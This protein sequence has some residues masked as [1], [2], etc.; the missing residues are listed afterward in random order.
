MIE[1]ETKH[2]NTRERERCTI[3]SM[4]KQIA[5]VITTT[6]KCYFKLL[7]LPCA[8]SGCNMAVDTKSMPIGAQPTS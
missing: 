7:H 1:G 4:K 2:K 6:I 5:L 3:H 8:T